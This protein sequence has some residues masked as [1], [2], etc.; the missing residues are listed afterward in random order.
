M[1]D[2]LWLLCPGNK[3]TSD[4]FR[5]G[6]ERI[7]GKNGVEHRGDKPLCFWRRD[8]LEHFSKSDCYEQEGR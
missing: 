7:W 3:G 5:E 4:A 2:R 1:G 8:K 6:Y